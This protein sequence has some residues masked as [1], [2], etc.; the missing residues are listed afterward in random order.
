MSYRITYYIGKY[1]KETFKQELSNEYFKNTISSILGECT[2]IKSSAIYLNFKNKVVK[3]PNLK[4]EI[5]VDDELKYIRST[6]I[7]NCRTFK[8]KFNQEAILFTIEEIE[9]EV[10]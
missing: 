9:Y 5:I 6:V 8:R 2:I 4:V 3:E 1:D 10:I 7:D